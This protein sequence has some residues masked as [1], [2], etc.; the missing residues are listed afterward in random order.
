M[1]ENDASSKAEKEISPKARK[2]RLQGDFQRLLEAIFEDERTSDSTLTPDQAMDSLDEMLATIA[3]ALDSSD[4]KKNSPAHPRLPLRTDTVAF[5]RKIHHYA[6][7]LYYNTYFRRTGKERKHG[8]GAPPL[9]DE[10]LDQILRRARKGMNPAQIAHELGQSDPG[11]KD[12]IRKQIGTAVKRYSDA[13]ENIRRLGAAQ[14]RENAVGLVLE[15]PRSG[16]TDESAGT[17]S[18]V[19]KRKRTKRKK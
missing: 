15:R 16:S 3:A 1:G 6:V 11:A 8:R 2:A 4:S 10:Y 17:V 14:L 9:P 7:D 13:A 18:K 12:R 19:S 5:R